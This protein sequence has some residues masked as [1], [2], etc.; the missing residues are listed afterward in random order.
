MKTC[1]IGAC[2]S[3]LHPDDVVCIL[4]WARVERTQRKAIYATKKLIRTARPNMRQALAR[5][6]HEQQSDVINALNSRIERKRA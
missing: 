6:L 2:K 4:H 5:K 3:P 1:P